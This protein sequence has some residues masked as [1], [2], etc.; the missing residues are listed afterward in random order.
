MPKASGPRS[1]ASAIPIARVP[2]LETK[3]LRTLQ[4]SALEACRARLDDPPSGAG[5][6]S[7]SSV[8]AGS[9]PWPARSRRAP[10]ARR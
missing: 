4:P 9:S 1:R 2:N 8:M 7:G 6:P 10:A 5:A 3:A